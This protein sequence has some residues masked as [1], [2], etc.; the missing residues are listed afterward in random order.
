MN[1]KVTVNARHISYQLSKTVV[2][3][4]TAESCAQALAG[5]VSHAEGECPFDVWTDMNTGGSFSVDVPSSFRSKLGDADGSILAVY[6][7][8]YEWDRYT[9]KLHSHRGRETDVTIR[10]GKNLTDI[11]KTTDSS[12][13]WTGIVPYW[14]GSDS[15]GNPLLIVPVPHVVAAENAEQYP[16]RML[17]PVDFSSSFQEA[18]TQAQL[19]AE[20]RDYI[21]NNAESSIPESLEIS[22]IALWQ[23][24]E[25]RDI[26]PLQRLSLC[27][28]VTVYH[29][30]L[31]VEAHAKIVSV[32]YD[33]LLE[34]Y[35]KMTLGEARSS[36]SDSIREM[37]EAVK[38]EIPTATFLQQAIQRATNLITGGRGGHVVLTLNADGQP[39][40]I[41][42]L[43]TEDIS[44]AVEVL[45]IN[46]NGIGF[47]HNG[48]EGPFE[49][50]WTL[51]GHFVADFIDTGTLS[52]TMIRGGFLR[53]GGTN[54]GNGVME[55]Y[56]G[57]GNLAAV[58]NNSFLQ[59]NGSRLI[60]PYEGIYNSGQNDPDSPY[61]YEMPDGRSTYDPETTAGAKRIWFKRR[62]QLDSGGQKFFVV[63]TH[64]PVNGLLGEPVV[65]KIGAIQATWS[66]LRIMSESGKS[67]GVWGNGW[68]SA[69]VVGDGS[70]HAANENASQQITVSAQSGL[71]LISGTPLRVQGYAN[72]VPLTFEIYPYSQ[73]MSS[74]L[75]LSI[76][77]SDKARFE[78]GDGDYADFDFSMNGDFQCRRLICNYAEVY[79]EKS[80]A[81]RT[82]QYGNRLLYCYEMPTPMFG[83]IG[84]AD[85]G[86]DGVAVIS[87][88]DVFSET[89]DLG[90]KY[91]V[92]LQKEGEGDLWVSQKEAAYFVV[93]GTPGLHFSWE[94]KAK[95]FDAGTTRL[96]SSGGVF[97]E[98]TLFGET[99]E[100]LYSEDLQ[101]LIDE[102]EE[103]LN[104]TAQFIYDAE[105]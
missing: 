86:E 67:I 101:D 52:A 58:M 92:F 84:E 37:T 20:A 49:T 35:E 102:Q 19:L 53:L 44:T 98:E 22:F 99:P 40:E 93:E 54:N 51:D 2:M 64:D 95:Q 87:I 100:Y 50:A 16:Y 71:A 103:L 45:R 88:D 80:R 105:H 75:G 48:Y 65:S 6:G 57:D 15:E 69:I 76:R 41:L 34:R 81:V 61:F 27:D 63:Q 43:D 73:G 33:V 28:T 68:G 66:G 13:V 8:E 4:F 3:P 72:N 1:G 79:N 78:G 12:G 56:D 31:G 89:I 24:E 90:M 18:P 83:D 36:L 62:L 104:E 47:S 23:T 94:L 7:G 26:A 29:K 11:K 14:S 70:V 32:T 42:I 5:L 85:I 77:R 55:I 82:E 30:E 46:R 9:V 96:E 91:Q 25:Y 59:W 17:I 21:S 74:R 38:K 10:Y 60:T 39:E 97:E